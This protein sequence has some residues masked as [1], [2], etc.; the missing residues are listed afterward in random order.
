MIFLT[1][2]SRSSARWGCFITN[3]ELTLS[4][5]LLEIL[6]CPKCKEKLKFDES[7]NKLICN[8]CRLKYRVED[9]IPVLLIDEAETF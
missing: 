3:K 6:A 8:R 2:D 4:D 7:A 1:T 9:A 5:E